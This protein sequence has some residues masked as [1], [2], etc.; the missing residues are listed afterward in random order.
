MVTVFANFFF[1]FLVFD[2]VNIK[3]KK[4]IVTNINSLTNQ[5]MEDV[6]R[7][8]EFLYYEIQK[9]IICYSKIAAKLKT[10]LI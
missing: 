4:K 10:R 2:A 6:E 1:F 5:F 7:K 3:K 8:R 9:F